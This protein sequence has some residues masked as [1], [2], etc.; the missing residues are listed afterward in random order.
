VVAIAR[1]YFYS[2]TDALEPLLHLTK[3]GSGSDA[4]NKV[5]VAHLWWSISEGFWCNINLV[6]RVII[7]WAPIDCMLFM[8]R[9]STVLLDKALILKSLSRQ[10]VFLST[11]KTFVLFSKISLKCFVLLLGWEYNAPTKKTYC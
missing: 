4:I 7:W 10:K 3:S 5:A 1:Y 8:N 11:F 9:L 6:G 2:V